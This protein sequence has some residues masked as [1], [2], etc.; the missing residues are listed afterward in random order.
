[1]PTMRLLLSYDGTDFMGWQIQ[2]RGRTVQAEVE[3]ALSAVLKQPI[4][5]AAAGRTDAGVHAH[6]QVVSFTTERM[7]PAEAWVPALNRELPRDVSVWEAQEVSSD[8]HARHSARSRSYRYLVQ[9]R[10]P[11]APLWARQANWVAG[12]VDVEAMREVW[13]ALEGQ[14]DF[15]AFGSSGSDPS[16]PNI[17]VQ[18]VALREEGDLIA[19]EIS[20]CHF[21]YHMVRRLVGTTLRVGRG[22][23][24]SEGFREVWAGRSARP[25]GPTAPPHGLSLVSVGYPP[26]F[27]WTQRSPQALAAVPA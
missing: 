27:V 20:A 4:R 18:H 5:T 22:L 21:L 6:G 26:A 8:F 13:L 12:P 15:S 9:V 10:G 23:L 7:I 16:D 3:R 11:R 25:S 17:T 1:M 14:H 24:T 19:F 2:S